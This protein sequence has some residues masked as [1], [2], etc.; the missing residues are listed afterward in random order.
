[1]Q[2]ARQPFYDFFDCRYVVKGRI[3]TMTPLH[4]G[5]ATETIDPLSVDNSVAKDAFNRP[6]IPGSSFKGVWRSFSEQILGNWGADDG[7]APCDM[8]GGNPCLSDANVKDI[9]RNYGRKDCDRADGISRDIYARMCRVCRLFGG[10]HFAGRVTVRDLMVEPS[11]WPGRFDQR[12]GVSIDRDTRTAVTGRKFDIEIVPAGVSF[13]MEVLV[14]NPTPAQRY[15]ALLGLLAFSRGDIHLG[16]MTSRGL[17][18]VQLVDAT[19]YRIDRGNLV[20]Y[21]TGGFP[22]ISG[23]DLAGA[24]EKAAEAVEKEG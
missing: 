15:N 13:G 23:V 18:K 10:L 14:D 24:W 2:A 16:G 21:L 7:P 11:T 22:A 6:V 12:P 9:K 20:K 1:M 3:V 4:I 8:V 5:G 19:A 17:G